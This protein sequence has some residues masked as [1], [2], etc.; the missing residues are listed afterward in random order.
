VKITR[1][2]TITT[3][4]VENFEAACRDCVFYVP[5]K[6]ATRGTCHAAPPQTDGWPAVSA[7]EGCGQ[8]EPPHAPAGA[9]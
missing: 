9:N 5:A 3:Q 8:F 7:D 4:T 1:T 2:R 6:P